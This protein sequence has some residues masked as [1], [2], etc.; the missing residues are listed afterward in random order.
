MVRRT[1]FHFNE[2][3]SKAKWLSL[4]IFFNSIVDLLEILLFVRSFLLPPDS[5]WFDPIVCS[6][7]VG[8]VLLYFPHYVHPD[9][10]LAFILQL[11]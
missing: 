7:Y 11:R 5:E 2:V 10:S 8:E 3:F 1:H 6:V 4:L 9:T